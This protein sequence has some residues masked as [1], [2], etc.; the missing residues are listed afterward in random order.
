SYHMYIFRF[1]PEQWSGVSRDKFLEALE[2]EGIPC[3]IGYT[4]PL[5]KNPLFQQMAERPHFC[6]V[7]CPYYGQLPDYRN[8]VCPNAERICSETCWI[9][10]SV[11]LA[12]E[13]DMTDIAGA[14]TRV[15]ENRGELAGA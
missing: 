11:L 4:T 13:S 14:I 12:E 3:S 5:Y 10:Q 9:P 2:A 6:P 7:S 1:L 15:W 8:T